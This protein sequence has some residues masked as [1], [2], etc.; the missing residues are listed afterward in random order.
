MKRVGIG[1]LLCLLLA[2]CGWLHAEPAAVAGSG[3]VRLE[4]LCPS[5]ALGDLGSPACYG[6]YS[7]EGVQ[8]LTRALPQAFAPVLVSRALFFPLQG[9]DPARSFLPR[10][11]P[12]LTALTAEGRQVLTG[13]DFPAA[14]DAYAG[15]VPSRYLIGRPGEFYVPFPGAPP[16][17][18]STWDGPMLAWAKQSLLDS[19]E[20]LQTDSPAAY[21]A[22]AGL[23]LAYD[24]DEAT[25]A[26]PDYNAVY[27]DAWRATWLEPHFTLVELGNRWYGDPAHFKEWSAV[28]PLPPQPAG[29]P[30]PEGLARLQA[31]YGAFCAWR[32]LKALNSLAAAIRK[33][34]PDK[35]CYLEL[36]GGALPV[37][38][39]DGRT[40][41][42]APELLSN[43]QA[44]AF[45]WTLDKSPA[46]PLQ[47]EALEAYA[48]LVARRAALQHKAAWLTKLAIAKA[49]PEDYE[50]LK[51][52]FAAG[53]SLVG[54]YYLD[55]SVR[56][57]AFNQR[58]EI[59][60]DGKTARF[61]TQ[62]APGLA[63]PSELSAA[64]VAVVC[65]TSPGPRLWPEVSAWLLREGVPVRLVLP[66][67]LQLAG[68]TA[69]R[70]LVVSDDVRCMPAG[71]S[72]GEALWRWLR[73][74]GALVLL[75]RGWSEQSTPSGPVP[76]PLWQRPELGGAP[77]A[78]GLTGPAARHI[79][80][81]FPRS[82][83]PGLDT[84]LA[85]KDLQSELFLRKIAGK[86]AAWQPTGRLGALSLEVGKGRFLWLGVAF[87]TALGR[88]TFTPS[89]PEGKR[90]LQALAAEIKTLAAR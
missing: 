87:Q 44:L 83:L 51:P 16:T 48:G 81:V 23:C 35:L 38:T 8:R 76:S 41:L 49:A 43:F 85:V 60:T 34:F 65:N 26:K 6:A 36:R 80:L 37:V 62:L 24:L 29:A 69:P 33:R 67:S 1:L 89:S 39:W 79:A 72:F 59:P 25:L 22:I 90:L 77:P 52:L 45:T 78:V 18:V 31:D 13:L 42:E 61:L 53:I 7:A 28:L 46:N 30:L 3:G 54:V 11:A 86:L 84:E 82:S 32:R 74:G 63:P 71:A 88:P 47:A 70:V 15:S 27:L 55:K 50:V 21:K 2:F 9:S 17:T 75:G 4:G 58:F 57:Q 64:P 19:L 10:L 12:V 40:L 56:P 14:V 5:L 20:Y 66:Q 73:Q 68:E